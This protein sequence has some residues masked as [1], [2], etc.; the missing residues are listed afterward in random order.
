[1]INFDIQ[2]NLQ[3]KKNLIKADGKNFGQTNRQLAQTNNAS[4]AE[5]TRLQI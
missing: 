2:L 5:N 3:K 1:M 4:V